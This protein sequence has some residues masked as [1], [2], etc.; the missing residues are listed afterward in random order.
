M[1]DLSGVVG[2]SVYVVYKILS[3]HDGVRFVL[4]SLR[5][6]QRRI[7]RIRLL[8]FVDLTQHVFVR[9]LESPERA[10]S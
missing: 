10:F 4:N 6:A 8:V 1:L 7:G 2:E 9:A 5:K 3:V